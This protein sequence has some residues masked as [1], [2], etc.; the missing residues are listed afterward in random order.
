MG[1][2]PMPKKA[3]LFLIKKF[4]HKMAGASLT[5]EILYKTAGAFPIK[6]LLHKTAG[7]FLIKPCAAQKEHPAA[8]CGRFNL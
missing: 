5:K 8:G 6:K 4:P 3:G 2:T 1:I 7:L